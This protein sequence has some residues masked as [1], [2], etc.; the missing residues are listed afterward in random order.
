MGYIRQKLG[1][2]F[3]KNY[4]KY[5]GIYWFKIVQYIWQ[6]FGIYW[7]IEYINQKLCDI[8]GKIVGYVRQK[9]GDI[10]WDIFVK[11]YGIYLPKTMGILGK[12]WD[13]LWYI[14]SNILK[15]LHIFG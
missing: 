9:V 12:L 6:N 8:L 11:S 14:I 1:L 4:G 5:Y 3:G 10:L 2:I 15:L 13:I 7:S